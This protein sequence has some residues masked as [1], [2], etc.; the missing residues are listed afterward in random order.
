[1]HHIWVSL[2]ERWWTLVIVNVHH[3]FIALLSWHEFWNHCIVLLINSR[4]VAITSA[5][6]VYIGLATSSDLWQLDSSIS[7][8]LSP[9]IIIRTYFALYTW[10]RQHGVVHV[11]P[12]LWCM[13]LSFILVVIDTVDVHYAD[14]VV[15]ILHAICATT[16]SKNSMTLSIH[17]SSLLARALQALNINLI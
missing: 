14:V 6:I 12:C 13:T 5:T 11:D 1:M 3:P 10:I 4:L 17:K 7:V 9:H 15:P 16:S 2:L 8:T